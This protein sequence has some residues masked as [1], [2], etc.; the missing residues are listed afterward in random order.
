MVTADE[1]MRILKMISAKQIT[2]EEGAGLLEALRGA[3]A[4]KAPGRNEPG[5][6]RWLRVRVTDRFSGRTKVNVNLP[7][8]LVDVGLKMGARFAPEMVGM[9][10]SA[11]QVALK[12]GVQGR[13]VAVDDEEDDERVEIFVE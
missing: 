13:I 9:D 8:G 7:I 2:A 6:A 5:R 1:R 4:A 3:P 12:A 10:L 11:I